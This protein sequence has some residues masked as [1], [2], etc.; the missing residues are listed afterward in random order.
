MYTNVLIDL[1]VLLPGKYFRNCVTCT[2]RW[3]LYVYVLL[4]S[5]ERAKPAVKRQWRSYLWYISCIGSMQTS[6]ED[7]WMM[8]RT[9]KTQKN[10]GNIWRSCREYIT[11]L[12]ENTKDIEDTQK[13]KN[14]YEI[15]GGH[16]KAERTS[17][18]NGRH[19]NKQRAHGR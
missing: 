11:H 9:Q 1:I 7:I 5:I 19:I 3:I 8:W 10:I 6:I 13:T 18:E 4:G 14:I 17:E 2:G 12:E 15:P 16:E